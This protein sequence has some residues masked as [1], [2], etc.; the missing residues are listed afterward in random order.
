MKELLAVARG[1][2]A[3]DFVIKGARIANVYTLEYEDVDV[4]VL[5][6]KIAG[7][8]SNYEG[9]QVVDA[10]GAVLI[11]GLI[12]GHVHIESTTL[13]PA[14][15]ADHVVTRGTTTV[16]ADPHEIANA[17][18]MRGIEYMYLAS[19]GLPVD[20]FLAASS[21]VPASAFETP[22]EE[23]EMNRIRE[24]FER[25]WCHHLG[26]VMNFPGVI[27][28]DD[29][30]WGK[31][32]A[33][34]NVPLTGHAPRVRGKDLCAYMTAGISSDHE[35]TDLEEAREKLR[36]GMWL[37]MRE[38]ASSPDMKN[39]LPLVRENPALSSRCMA[40]S[41]DITAK[42]IVQTGH[43][44]EKIRIMIGEGL[45]P[46]VALRM[47]TLSPASYFGLKDRGAIGPG[48]LADLV[49]VKNL[50]DCTVD[51]VW[52]NG[53]LTVDNGRLRRKHEVRV[54]HVAF[55]TDTREIAPLSA[56]QIAIKA[57]G[58][59]ELHV[60][61]LEPD[62]L[63]TRTLL[64][65][66]TVRDG[67]AVPDKDRDLAKIVVQ[68][69]HRG[70]G[71]FA[72]GFVKGLGMQWGAMASSVAHDAHNFVAAGMDDLSLET[73]LG[74]LTR[75][76]GGLVLAS[77]SKVVGYFALPV[78]GLMTTLDAESASRGLDKMEEKAKEMGIGIASPFMV[79]S[80][81]CL[82]VIPELKITD[83]GYIDLAKGGIRP[84]FSFSEFR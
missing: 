55:Q 71:R 11:P 10:N 32:E 27:A 66:P 73:A 75:N 26:E 61:G 38:G 1:E 53:R 80:F 67:L 76:G 8:G 22:Y 58:G 15:F 5:G 24:L 57:P 81:L 69:R 13:A 20:V 19:R 78:A 77:E 72:V 79:L 43:M 16:M 6:D 44:D 7:V 70:T 34:G 28:G 74:H 21:C 3:A 54:E 14:V 60:I 4:A 47:V 23:M 63:A 62:S 83:Q 36:R 35:S 42:Y 41:D 9:K 51:K 52:K 40:V 59:A 18:G 25:G 29:A 46:L 31:I 64:M 39:L 45:N 56:E 68:E 48:L 65:A 33:A 2:K 30:V 37:M 49:L 82:T 50:Q 84:L 12:D 17:L